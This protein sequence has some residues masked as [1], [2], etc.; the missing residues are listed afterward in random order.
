[1]NGQPRLVAVAMIAVV[2]LS[3]CGKWHGQPGSRE[4]HVKLLTSEAAGRSSPVPLSWCT[5]PQ[6]Q[7]AATL[8]GDHTV[9]VQIERTTSATDEPLVVVTV[10]VQQPMDAMAR[11]VPEEASQG[12]CTSGVEIRM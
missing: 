11:S 3:A 10:G 2:C 12:R 6:S 8:D 1:M 5:G 9:Y 4:P 7:A